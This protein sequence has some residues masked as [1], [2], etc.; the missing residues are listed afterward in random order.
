VTSLNRPYANR[1]NSGGSRSLKGAGDFLEWELHAVRF[2]ERAGYD[3]IYSTDIDTHTLGMRLRDFKVVMSVGHDEYWTREMYDAFEGA[4]NAGVNLA[5]LGS[6]IAYWG[7]RIQPAANGDPNRQVVAYRHWA[8]QYDPLYNTNRS[9]AM[10]RNTPLN[11]PESALIGV[12]Y[13]YN[14][15]DLDMVVSDCTTLTWICAGSGLAQG[16]V[17]TG[18]VGYE[19]DIVTPYSPAGVVQLARSPYV[20]NGQTRYSSMTYYT[21]SSGAGVF[22]TGSLQWVWGLDTSAPYPSRANPATET[23]TRN[24]IDGFLRLK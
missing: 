20:V 6:N 3:L 21:H 23:L 22:A 5:F 24:I 19:V 11:R 12:Q 18:L 4:R 1:S 13:D 10:W 7:T 17:L 16:S 14:T 15:V 9:T 2:L 8:Q